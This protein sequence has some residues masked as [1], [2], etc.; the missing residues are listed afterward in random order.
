VNFSARRKLA[1]GFTLIEVV[2]A[3]TIV[4]LGVVILLQIFSQ[5]LRLETRSTARTE[6]VARSGRAMDELLA[7]KK[8]VEGSDNGRVGDDARW[9][10]QIRTT[11]DNAAA[12]DLS[13]SWELKEVALEFIVTDG[14]R[15]R[16]IELK[17]LRLTKK[18]NR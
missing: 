13:N 16:Q 7:R 1:K 11:R 9:N 5:G 17:T 8:L 3:M 15:K 14:E 4:G 2:V 10:A 6:A 18:T 12:L